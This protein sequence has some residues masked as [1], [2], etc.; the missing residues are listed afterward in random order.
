MLA[1]QMILEGALNSIIIQKIQ[2][3]LQNIG[4]GYLRL[5][6]PVVINKVKQ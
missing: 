5:F 6:I 2:P 1:I 3:L 4:L